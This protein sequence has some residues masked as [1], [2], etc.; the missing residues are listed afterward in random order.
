MKR[1]VSL[2]ANWRI[3]GRALLHFV[4]TDKDRLK[5]AELKSPGCAAALEDLCRLG[6]SGIP[7]PGDVASDRSIARAAGLLAV[8][9]EIRIVGTEIELV[10]QRL[11]DGAGQVLRSR[12]RQVMKRLIQSGE[13]TAVRGQIGQVY[14]LNALA[15]RQGWIHPDDAVLGRHRLV[16]HLD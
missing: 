11:N 1:D 8:D 13:R 16:R 5:E 10:A 6:R 15:R 2:V 12:G 9:A 3:V 4:R 7:D 14:G